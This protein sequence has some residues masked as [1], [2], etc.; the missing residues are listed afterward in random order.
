MQQLISDSLF[1]SNNF[2]ITVVSS[3]SFF[4]QVSEIVVH[5]I[6]SINVLA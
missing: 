2:I 4:L 6:N 5:K 3:R 1:D